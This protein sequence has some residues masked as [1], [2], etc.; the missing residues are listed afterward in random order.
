MTPDL[1]HPETLSDRLRL[2]Q[3]EETEEEEEEEEEGTEED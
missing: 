2:R 3:E 1:L